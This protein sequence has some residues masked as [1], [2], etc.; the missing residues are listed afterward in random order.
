M[1]TEV[2]WLLSSIPSTCRVVSSSCTETEE[3]QTEQVMHQTWQEAVMQPGLFYVSQNDLRK[4]VRCTLQASCWVLPQLKTWLLR[5]EMDCGKC[6]HLEGPCIQP[7]FL[8]F[9][10]SGVSAFALLHV[11]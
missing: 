7:S 8:P 10:L 3:N 6:S 2:A 9:M 1:R 4:W 11:H 5:V